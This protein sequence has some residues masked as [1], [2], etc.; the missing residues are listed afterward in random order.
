MQEAQNVEQEVKINWDSV[1]NNAKKFFEKNLSEMNN[2]LN[3]LIV[4]KTGVGKST[5][6]NTVFGNK[7][8]KT[9]S[10]SPITQE[11]VAIHL[12]KNFTIYDTK[13]LEMNDFDTTFNS[14]KEFIETDR[15]KKAN[16]QIKVVWLCIS[17]A[18]RRIEDGEKRLYKLFKNKGYTIVIA[19]TKAVQDKDE[20]GEKFSDVVKRNFSASDSE[21]QRVRAL[22][23][24]DDE[25]KLKPIRGIDELIKKT[26]DKLPVAS[27]QAF[28]RE[29]KY[30]KRGGFR[31]DKYI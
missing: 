25:G 3:V 28:A 11:I 10:G 27:K 30:K 26:Y 9:G 17:E 31:F 4:G 12:N 5:L 29:Q 6:I 8:A 16:E 23:I 14:I 18:G 21:I 15:T 22:E 20:N 7:V 13:G 2:K 24:E 1:I 19:I